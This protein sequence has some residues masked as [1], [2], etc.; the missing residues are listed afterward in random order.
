MGTETGEEKVEVFVTGGSGFVGGAAIR[1]LV[2]LGYRV[3]ALSRS[4]DGDRAIRRAG[5]EPVR[6]DLATVS[7]AHLA[8]CDAVVHAAAFVRPWGRW[9]DFR[10]V[11][12][13]GTARLLEAARTAAVRRF[14]H[15][16]TEAALFRGRPMR[17]I[18]E[19]A[20]LALDAPYPYARTKAEAE[21]L[22]LAADDPAA[23]F[24]TIVLRPRMIWGPG[25]RTILPGLLRMVEGGG[26]AWVDGGRART[27]TTHIANLVHAIA[28]ALERGEGGT[29][30]FVTDGET[31]TLRDFLSRLAG[32]RGVALPDRSV[33]GWMLRALAFVVESFWRLLAI[34]REPPITRMVAAMMAC[35]CTLRIDRARAELGYEPPITVA[36]GLRRL[37]AGDAD[38]GTAASETGRVGAG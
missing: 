8:A 18:D 31:T 13:E 26:F 36:E 17:D 38:G 25:D 21:R 28:L 19:R 11:N 22:V 7:A 29:A 37:A 5:G 14:V 15:I 9:R 24:R 27:S 16:G 30:L 2:G 35:D 6:G 20:P 33:P 4:E 12:V 23:G 32:T 34:E 10:R 1:H 3:R